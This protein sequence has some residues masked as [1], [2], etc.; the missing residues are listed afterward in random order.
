M[1]KYTHEIEARIINESLNSDKVHD[2]YNIVNVY[3]LTDEI[4]KRKKIY[5]INKK[6]GFKSGQEKIYEIN[7]RFGV[8]KNKI[9]SRSTDGK[10]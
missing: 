3:K 2:V 1:D 4:D 6:F 7:K 8:P 9:C 5:E 10:E